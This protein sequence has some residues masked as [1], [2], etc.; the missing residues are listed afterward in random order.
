M[1]TSFSKLSRDLWDF[2]EEKNIISKNNLIFIFQSENNDL[3]RES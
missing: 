3:I 2:S 1:N